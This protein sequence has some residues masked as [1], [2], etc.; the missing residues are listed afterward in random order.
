MLTI[1]NNYLEGL[2]SY[3]FPSFSLV[4]FPLLNTTKLKE[5]VFFFFLAKGI[6]IF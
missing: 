3:L 2:Q 4:A 6:L 5:I 1:E